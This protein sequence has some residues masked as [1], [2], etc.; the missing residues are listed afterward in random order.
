MEVNIS[1]ALKNILTYGIEE[2]NRIGNDYV[3]VEH[4]FL[5]ILREGNNNAVK[6]LSKFNIDLK[7]LKKRV[8][9]AIEPELESETFPK[10]KDIQLP[11]N[12][13]ID[14]MLKV[15]YLES[16]SL[17]QEQ[18][19]PEHTLLAILKD[20]SAL[21]TGI[22]NTMGVNYE[23]YRSELQKI[24]P[25][26]HKSSDSLEGIDMHEYGEDKPNENKNSA[27]KISD[28]K[29]KTPVLDNF[30][31]DLIKAAEENRLDPIV[32]RQKELDRIAQILSRRKK[33]N[34]ILIGEPGVGKSAIAEGLALRIVQ[35][36][37]P[38]I[39]LC[40]RIITLDIASIVAGTKYR[41]QF[42]ERMK[43]I[44]NELEKH[45]E[46]IVFMDEIHTIVGAGN[47]SGALDAS[48]M[49]KPALARG[50]IQC[51]GATT[52]DEYRQCIEKDGALERRFQKVIIEATTPAETL[53]I[54]QNIKGKYEDH[55]L[56][57][58][59]EEALKACVSYTNRYITDRFLPDKAIDA[60]D[61]AGAK[62]HIRDVQTSKEVEEIEGQLS[63]AKEDMMTAIKKQEFETAAQ[64]RD[65]M[66]KLSTSLEEANTAWEKQARENK[67]EVKQED[68]AE[69]IA[70]M[71]GVPIQKVAQNEMLQLLKMEEQLQSLV[72]GQNE[73]IHNIVRAIRRNRT[74]LKDP[75]RP[76]G[77]FIFLGPTG[78]GKT[79]LTKM[80]SKYMFDSESALIRIDMS[81]YMEKFAVSRLIGSPPGYV[82][83]EDG[84]QLTEKVR[85]KPYSIVLFD[86]IEK[87]HPDIFHL[88]LQVLDDGQ[89]TDGLGRKVDFKNTIIIMTSNLGSR[90]VKD[91][92]QGVGFY[93]MSKEAEKSKYARAIIEKALK[94]QFAPEFLNRIDEI[95]VFNNLE[96]KDI[97]KIIDMEL[98]QLKDRLQEMGMQ[99]LVT[100][101]AKSFL[102][103]KG[104]DPEFGA[105]P[106]KR[107]IE[108]YV[109]D[110]LAEEIVKGT[111][112]SGQ[113]IVIDSNS[114][115]K[116]LDITTKNGEN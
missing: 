32:G 46:I 92:G 94:K 93:T 18:V 28:P 112:K 103:E 10:Q 40:K 75:S 19:E 48:N 71:S 76:I 114:E 33:N 39:L 97:F 36:K 20:E 82:G 43:A 29:S 63:I 1:E 111:L 80:L 9:E 24:S 84:G 34:P 100:E 115:K 11:L 49:L 15:M 31:R 104:W 52:L 65:L 25:L 51:I 107:A 101:G 110:P 26:N 57:S 69:V 102:N 62:V 2:A 42:E 108:R 8:E 54:L 86:E 87:A 38:R 95:V 66:S 79:Y 70:M 99:L 64:I 37:V 27:S 61:E 47:T 83:Y 81:E 21:L 55:H 98:I 113:T 50:E 109:E 30:G 7:D 45:P 5:G 16:R 60:L 73:A 78:V 77:S 6:A 116:Q 106:L 12:K 35:K 58:Y 3:G 56:V 91:F 74:G 88:L 67:I 68:V 53:E 22:L 14:R 59:S 85:R 105:R 89:L 23:N 96:Q 41:G 90:Q 13:Q 17:Q 4:V 44:L 72:I